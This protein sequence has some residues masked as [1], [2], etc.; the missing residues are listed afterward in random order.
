MASAGLATP[1]PPPGSNLAAAANALMALVLFPRPSPAPPLALL[2]PPPAPVGIVVA[3]ALPLNPASPSS[4]SRRLTGL[5]IAELMPRIAR[6]V[7]N[8]VT[9]GSVDSCAMHGTV[10]GSDCCGFN[11]CTM[12]VCVCVD[13]AHVLVFV[14]VYRKVEP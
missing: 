12:Y 2:P 8:V 13:A 7:G 9:F 10:G 11:S 6:Y 1:T 14:F 4:E 5:P 3:A